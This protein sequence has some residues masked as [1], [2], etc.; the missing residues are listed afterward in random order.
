[1]LDSGRSIG[2]FR[3]E[4]LSAGGALLTGQ[5][6]QV[7]GLFAV[8]TTVTVRLLLPGASESIEVLAAVVRAV[9]GNT[10][11]TE[12][13]SFAVRFRNVSAATEDL[14]QD[15][16]LRAIEESRA[17][18]A[19]AILVLD[20]S[21]EDRQR[22]GQA[23][24]ALGQS[25]FPADNFLEALRLLQDQDVRIEVA[26]VDVLVRDASG[27]EVLAFLAEEFGDVRRVLMSRDA[28]VPAL[29]LA[30]SAGSAHA[31]LIKPAEPA[32]LA[33]AIGLADWC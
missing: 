2:P 5:I 10:R 26:I 14:I 19:P 23:L 8:G 15:A 17:R 22:L 30:L 4:N 28:D 6:L 18:S 32:D 21:S 3:V 13:F 12:R 9:E 7:V 11:S 16:V 27:P 29:G 1:M 33:A 20:E 31:I 25:A 24:G